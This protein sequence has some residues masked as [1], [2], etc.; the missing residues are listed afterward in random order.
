MQ[1]LLRQI[2]NLQVISLTAVKDIETLVLDYVMG[3]NL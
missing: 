3:L 1:C 2:V